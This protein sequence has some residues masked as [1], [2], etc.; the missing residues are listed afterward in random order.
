MSIQLPTVHLNGTSKAELLDTL[1]EASEALDAA[2][3]ALCR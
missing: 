1:G 3:R 2:Y